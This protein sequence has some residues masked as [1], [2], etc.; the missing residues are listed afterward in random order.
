MKKDGRMDGCKEELKMKGL[1]MNS[2]S[3]EALVIWA[4]M[5]L[6]L[7]SSCFGSQV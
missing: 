7:S 3:R 1:I 2:Y 5:P 6:S 4:A